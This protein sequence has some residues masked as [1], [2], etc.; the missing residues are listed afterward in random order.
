[1]GDLNVSDKLSVA[2]RG[3][4]IDVNSFLLRSAQK[5]AI[6]QRTG[7]YR[8]NYQGRYRPNQVIPGIIFF[9][10]KIYSPFLECLKHLHG[11]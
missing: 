11:N 8:Y 3:S 4:N 6:I 10:H 2:R 1:V 7:D 9:R 5:T